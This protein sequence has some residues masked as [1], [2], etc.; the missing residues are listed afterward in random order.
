MYWFGVLAVF[1]WLYLMDV[2]KKANWTAVYTVIGVVG[3]FFLMIYLAN[4]SMTNFLMKA[5]AFGAGIFGSL[6]GFY[7]VSIQYSMIQIHSGQNTINLFIT[8]ECSAVIEL[9]AYISLT[10]FYP[11]FDS[12]QERG[13]W[14]AL[15]LFK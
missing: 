3:L 15:Y 8:Y 2:M 1:L 10:L 9:I 11:F 13:Y 5:S 4:Y 6:T 12:I 7:D 14:L